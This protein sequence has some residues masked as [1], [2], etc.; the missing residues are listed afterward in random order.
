LPESF[1]FGNPQSLDSKEFWITQTAKSYIGSSGEEKGRLIVE[2][3]KTSDIPRDVMFDKEW[4]G[5]F[6][7]RS[8]VETG[9]GANSVS[10]KKKK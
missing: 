10:A 4:F 3:E 9:K 2:I 7:Y 5:F 8:H 1:A 6:K